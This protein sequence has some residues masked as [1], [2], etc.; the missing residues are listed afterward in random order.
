[1]SESKADVT[2]QFGQIGDRAL[3]G[4]FDADGRGDLV[5]FRAGENAWT[6]K[7]ADGKEL[8]V[9]LAGSNADVPAAGDFDGDG[10]ADPSVFRPSDGVWYFQRT[11]GGFTAIP[12]GANGDRPVSGA[13]VP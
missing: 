9:A 3:I 8:S 12:F 5:T 1:M 6:I 10:K 7:L 2:E 4:D 11:T 13:F